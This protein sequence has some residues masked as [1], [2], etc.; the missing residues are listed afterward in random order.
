MFLNYDSFNISDV[1]NT[2]DYPV[3]FL[4]EIDNDDLTNLVNIYFNSYTSTTSE[5]E[6][7]I[8]YGLFNQFINK[9]DSS[10][11][12]PSCIYN[13]T[14]S[15]ITSIDYLEF[16]ENGELNIWSNGISFNL[17]EPDTNLGSEMYNCRLEVD[18]VVGLKIVDGNNNLI[19]GMM[20]HP[21]NFTEAPLKSTNKDKLKSLLRQMYFV[22][23]GKKR[24]NFG[25][26]RY[27]NC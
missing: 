5:D 14:S 7:K 25:E 6:L 20:T 22:R 17:F 10:T 12:Y 15:S 11:Q 26:Y 18:N 8:R 13:I 9:S 21:T 23:T 27:I 2:D 19:W 24:R 4:S 16:V 1:Y 3:D